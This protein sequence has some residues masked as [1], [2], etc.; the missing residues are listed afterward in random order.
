MLKLQSWW[1]GAKSTRGI[2]RRQLFAG[3]SE[4]PLAR[5]VGRN[6]FV[7]RCFVKVGPQHVG[8]MKFTV[9]QLPQQEVAD[10][11]LATVRMNKSGSGA[12]AMAKWGAKSDSPKLP[13]FSGWASAS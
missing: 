1:Y 9:G 11:L 5:G 3:A 8:E 13:A 12:N 2:V 4:T 10:A 6:R 7:E